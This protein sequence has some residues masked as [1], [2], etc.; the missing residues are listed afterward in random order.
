MNVIAP[1]RIMLTGMSG[2]V[3]WE[4][5]RTLAPLG[6]VVALNRR[7]LDLAVPGQIRERV[8][9]IKPN[10][11]V[12][13]AAYTAVDKAEEEMELCRAVNGT[14]P[15]ILAEE[16][17]SLNA[18][19]IHY[20][21]D[22]V[23]D[24]T[25][26]IPYVEDDEPNPLNIYGRTK[27]EGERA[28]QA[29]GVP[30]LILR[31]SGVYGKRGKNFMLTVLRLAREKGELK[32][33]DDQVGSPTW[34]RMIAEAT[35]QILARGYYALLERGGV[36]HLSAGGET[37]WYGFA[38]ATLARSGKPGLHS[39]QIMPISTGQYRSVARR[40]AYAVLS[41]GKLNRTFGI[42]LPDWEAALDLVMD[43]QL[44]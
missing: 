1:P 20:S 21:T 12:N 7:Q 32:V 3:G 18:V 17:K 30:H 42:A 34:S 29:V 16:A 44:L 23:F 2:Q 43:E 4:L 10:L 40:P 6:A 15:G 37:S 22:Y 5:R 36:Y 39:V 19:L 38:R 35:A 8:R 14:A 33:V 11:I 24:G 25:K 31:V 27:L 41:N 9:E 26:K 28:V 13:A